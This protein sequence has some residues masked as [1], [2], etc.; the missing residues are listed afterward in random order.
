MAWSLK[1]YPDTAKF[2]SLVAE[3]TILKGQKKVEWRI[4]EVFQVDSEG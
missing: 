4:S 3:G 1:R 2:E